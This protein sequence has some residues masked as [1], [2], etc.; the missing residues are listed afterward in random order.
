MKQYTGKY[1]TINSIEDVMF[2]IALIEIDGMTEE[3]ARNFLINDAIPVNGSVT[4]L[5]YYSQTEPIACEYYGD[6]M[7]L[8]EEIYCKDVPFEVIK[9]LNNL[10]WFAWEYI[11]LGNEEN[12]NEIIE[13]A[14]DKKLIEFDDEEEQDEFNES[15]NDE[16][17]GI[18][19][20]WLR[21]KKLI[22]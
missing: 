7:Y 16:N 21:N 4:S 1:L 6:I 19:Y 13:I 3:E 9:S 22:D 2:D 5:I 20:E 17:N 15:N 11:V 10:T 14:K 8:I 12:V 18:D